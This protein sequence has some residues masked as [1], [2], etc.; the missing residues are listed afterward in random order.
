MTT[1]PDL[2]HREHVRHFWGGRAADAPRDWDWHSPMDW[3]A[4]EAL[5]GPWTWLQPGPNTK[6]QR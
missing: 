2:A 4:A 5:T 6:A 3:R 1:L